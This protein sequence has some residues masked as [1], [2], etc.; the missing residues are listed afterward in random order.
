[1]EE[2]FYLY[3]ITTGDV[4]LILGLMSPLDAEKYEGGSLRVISHSELEKV[5]PEQL[6]KI[7]K[8]LDN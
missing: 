1:M 4:E 8:Y 6:K 3:D 2:V 7:T 5:S